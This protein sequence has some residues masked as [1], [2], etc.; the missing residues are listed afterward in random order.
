MTLTAVDHVQLAIPKGGEAL[1]RPFYVDVL[2]LTE[3][4]KPANLAARGGAWFS[5]GNVQLHL[6]VDPEFHP[7]T[8]AHPAFVVSDVRGI[9]ARARAHGY[10]VL[11]DDPLP[12][13]ERVFV[14]DPF[15]NRIELM[16]RHD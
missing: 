16:E 12:G 7:A 4:E 2:G 5:S 13:F 11:D 14:Y 10:K 9:A 8:K 6:G 1:A 15:G 3:L